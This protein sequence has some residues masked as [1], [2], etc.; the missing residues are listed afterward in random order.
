MRGR[1]VLSCDW[2]NV[3]GDV[4]FLQ[5]GH[6]F[7]N[8]RRNFCRHMLSVPCGLVQRG[9]KLLVLALQGGLIQHGGHRDERLVLAVPRGL[10]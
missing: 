8:T 9:E 10:I 7:D 2:R 5:R 6:V 3:R 4:L 1:H